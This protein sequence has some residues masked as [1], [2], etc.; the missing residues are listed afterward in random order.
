[1]SYHDIIILDEI[2]GD[3]A[4]VEKE[5]HKYAR[6][7][8]T[9]LGESSERLVQAGGKRLRPAFVLLSGKFF[10]YDLQAIG[11]LAVAIEL[12]H[13][14]TLVHD[15]VIDSA[16]TRRG[17]PTV[18][19][20]WGDPIALQTG[21]YLFA[22][23]LKIVAQYGNQDIIRVLAGVSLEMCEGEIEQINNI[24]NTDIGLRTYL[25][26]I[27]RKTA[28]LISACC[29]IGALAGDAPSDLTW[30][31][32]RYGYYLGMAFQITDDILD[33]TGSEEVFGKPVGSDLRQGIITI[34][35][36]YTL[37]DQL[38]GPQLQTII[39]KGHKKES[40]WEDAFALIEGAGALRASQRLCERYL[41]KAKEELLCLPDI[42][43]R[44]ILVALADFIG[45]R[46]Y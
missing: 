38:R 20:Q 19:A 16:A 17:L 13:M 10:K 8:P 21:S 33:F 35:V 11:Q 3:L 42:P 45:T 32:K 44:R 2:H 12:I 30:H 24:G 25:R 46:N 14:A 26:R 27:Q 41:Q 34:P 5:L 23:A 29:A 37:K 1:M 18:C 36:I 39:E 31:L 22:Q 40:D 15:D 6:A 4:Y 9:I 7:S 28:L 43:P